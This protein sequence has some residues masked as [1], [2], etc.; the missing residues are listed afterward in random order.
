MFKR[1]LLI[2]VMAAPALAALEDPTRPP[3]Q[4]PAAA[5]SPAASD[6]PRW[7]LTTTL[8]SPERRTAVINN[9]VVTVGDRIGGARVVD[10]Q[11]DSVRLR[12]GGREVTLM[13]VSTNVKQASKAQA[14]KRSGT[15]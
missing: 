1:G 4:A 5:Q 9:Q 11:A 7:L 12:A 10:I 3:V 6:G 14:S 8:V 13:I 2:L 15:P